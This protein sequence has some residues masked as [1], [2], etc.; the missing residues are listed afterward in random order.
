MTTTAVLVGEVFS[1]GSNS[2]WKVTGA[3]YH[4]ETVVGEFYPVVACDK[5]GREFTRT[6]GYSAD[7]VE[8][9]KRWFTD[10]GKIG[11]EYVE[12]SAIKRS[13]KQY[14]EGI[15]VFEKEI[16]NLKAKLTTLKI[17]QPEESQLTIRYVSFSTTAGQIF[18]RGGTFWKIM[19]E[20]SEGLG[21][22]PYYPVRECT[23]LGVLVNGGRTDRINVDFG[24]K[25]W[26]VEKGA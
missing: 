24:T 10:D 7:F 12:S 9:A 25:R 2:Y 18:Q 22:A 23:E 16:A 15:A 26:V 13:I 20:P 21:G 1:D 14:E 19:G 6:V 3:K 4:S 5:N 17:Q 11:Y 8:K